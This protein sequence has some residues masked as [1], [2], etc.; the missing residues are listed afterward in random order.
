MPVGGHKRLHVRQ[1][2]LEAQKA[3]FALTARRFAEWRRGR[4]AN[5]WKLMNIDVKKAHLE[6]TCNADDV[7][8]ALQEEDAKEDQCARLR[9]W[10]WGLRGVARG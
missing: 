3:L 8:I 7:H 2:A 5:F 1:G 10:L 9:K 4:A 6:A